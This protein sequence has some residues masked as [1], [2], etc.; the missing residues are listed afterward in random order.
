MKR[1]GIGLLIAFCLAGAAAV[2]DRFAFTE[3]FGLWTYTLGT[4]AG[5]GLALL[6]L[7]LS[8]GK[9]LS[10]RRKG[11]GLGP[12]LILI[13]VTTFLLALLVWIAASRPIFS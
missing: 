6:G 11:I 4:F 5:L 1:V 8:I 2:L 13:G 3:K 7:L 10:A 12:L 9:L